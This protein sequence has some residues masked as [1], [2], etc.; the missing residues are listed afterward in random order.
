MGKTTGIS[1][2]DST[3]NPWRGCHRVSPGCANCYMF[4]DMRR[5]GGDPDVVVRSKTTFGD[6]LKWKIP[7]KIF[8]CSWSDF[9]IEE[10]DE[11]R[12]EAWEIMRKTPHHTY[13]LC[14]KRPENILSR[15]PKDWG[16]GYP[17][18]WLGVTGE[19]QVMFDRRTKILLSIPAK[20]HWVSVEPM[21]EEIN[22][23]PMECNFMPPSWG[24]SGVDWVVIGGESGSNARP[25]NTAWIDSFVGGSFSLFVKQLGTN[26]IR[27][28]DSVCETIQLKHPHGADPSEW[29]EKYRVQEFPVGEKDEK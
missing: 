23:Y 13:Q 12:D 22:P 17:N 26:P 14:T 24:D 28:D 27:F 8:V 7:R 2:T 15:L 6:P 3:W 21:L 20:I 16:A 29:E 18:V 10:A 5:Y 25:F 4:R 9:F 11:W 19:N 1:W